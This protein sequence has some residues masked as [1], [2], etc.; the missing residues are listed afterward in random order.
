M[1]KLLLFAAMAGVSLIYSPILKAQGNGLISENGAV[2]K[3]SVVTEE[4]VAD[5]P[6]ILSVDGP[7]LSAAERADLRERLLIL[8]ENI[9]AEVENN[10]ISPP[11]LPLK[12][13]RQTH[14]I[15][16]DLADFHGTPT[17]FFIG[18]NVKNTRAST[19]GV[20]STLA[21]PSAANDGINI[22]YGGNT[23]VEF[24]TNGGTT[25][26]AVTI[27]AGP[28]DAPI[29]CCDIDVIHDQARG[30]T[31]WSVLYV[32]QALTNGVVRIFVRRNI[33]D[34]NVCS[35]TI[36]PAG[37]ANNILPDYPHLGI[38][39]NHLY[40]AT[41]N[42]GASW[43]GAQVRRFN[44]DQMVDCLGVATQ[45]F[46]YTSATTGQR[47]VVPVEGARETM[48]WGML[49]NTTT[50]RVFKWPQNAAAPTSVARSISASTFV[51]PDCRGGRN[52]RDF[53]ERSTAFSI[54]GFRLR[55]AVGAGNI[56]FFWNVG[57]DASHI[58]GHVHAA[59]FRESN[60]VLTG[61]PHIFNNGFCFGFPAV[62]A[63]ERGNFGI[64]IAAGGK[65]GGGGNAVRGFVGIDDDYTTGIGVFGTVFLTA[66]GTHNPDD[67]RYGDYFTIHP[68]EPCDLFFNATNY[69][70]SGGTST[71]NVN[72]RYIEFGRERDKTCYQGW[73]DETRL[74]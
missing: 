6:D 48:Y 53:I 34:G 10:P 28:A 1:R 37:T 72:A 69:A 62:S 52:N 19:N 23:H 26:T 22:F 4:I 29:A 20:G 54:T 55:G 24:S 15:E 33:P 43:L 49:D 66:S 74:P 3:Y 13:G 63:N 8:R 46:T 27:P 21:E 17:G 41:N 60:L 30:V 14:V 71:T 50:F 44:I 58:Q 61:Q 9:A 42:I 18:R 40:L 45:T 16:T 2:T 64:T 12:T 68:H 57:P 39:N 11:G 25:W 70:L 73:R 32:N 31:F 47:V 36:D 38:S 59:V 35:Y 67:N 65:S 5:S 7:Q 56:A 51:N